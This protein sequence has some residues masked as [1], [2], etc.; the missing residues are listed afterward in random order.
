MLDLHRFFGGAAVVF[1]GFHVATIAVDSY[2]SFGLAQLFI[3]LAS[4]WHPV[5][6]AWGVVALYLLVA[7]EVTS[8]LRAHLNRSLWRATHYAS[9]PLFALVSIHA[10]SAGTDRH[11]APMLWGAVVVIAVV[12]VLTLLRL[13]QAEHHDVLTAPPTTQAARR[14]GFHAH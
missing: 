6:V 13:F 11:T 5:A 10:L 1:T 14:P 3:P 4:S 12:V 9:F 8:L 7:V 2:V